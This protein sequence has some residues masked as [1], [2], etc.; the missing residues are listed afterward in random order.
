MLGFDDPTSRLLLPA[1]YAERDC[2]L[3]R[4]RLPGLPTA[5]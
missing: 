3:V 2:L 5:T 4:Y 1:G